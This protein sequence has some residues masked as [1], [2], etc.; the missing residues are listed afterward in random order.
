MSNKEGK[1]FVLMPLQYV[2]VTNYLLASPNSCSYF[3]FMKETKYKNA[4]LKAHLT[5]YPFTKAVKSALPSPL[6][7][8]QESSTKIYQFINYSGD[9]YL[10]LCAPLF[11]FN[12]SW[13]SKMQFCVIYYETWTSIQY[14]V[15]FWTLEFCSG[16]FV[17]VEHTLH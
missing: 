9:I 13:S 15:A 10:R 2:T 3:L 12:V 8:H 16:F 11:Q 4:H 17:L 7:L 14:H 5:V 6:L 1:F